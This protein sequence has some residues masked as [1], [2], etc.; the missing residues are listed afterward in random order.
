[1]DISDASGIVT[2]EE[3]VDEVCFSR[4]H[5]GTVERHEQIV[6]PDKVDQPVRIGEDVG[7]DLPLSDPGHVFQ[8][9]GHFPV[10][11]DL[12]LVV[13]YAVVPP[14][15]TDIKPHPGRGVEVNQRDV[16]LECELYRKHER[17]DGSSP[18]IQLHKRGMDGMDR[19]NFLKRTYQFDAVHPLE[20]L[21]DDQF[22]PVESGLGGQLENLLQRQGKQ[23]PG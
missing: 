15:E 10:P 9:Y 23:A 12:F 17:L 13:M 2:E 16:A 19:R 18:P 5:M 14:P 20:I 4:P 1:M 3:I 6:F 21:V 8:G 22:D 7:V 11:S